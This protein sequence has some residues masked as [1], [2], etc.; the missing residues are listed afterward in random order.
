MNRKPD[1]IF[2]TKGKSEGKT[3]LNAFDNALLDAKIGN[4]NLSRVSSIVPKGV[5]IK[6]ELF[7][8]PGSVVPCVYSSIVSSEK[9]E[10]LSACVGAGLSKDSFGLIFE[11][12]HKGT[13]KIAEEIV[14][15]MIDEGFENRS[16]SLDKVVIISVEHK[17]QRIGSAIAAAV[18]WWGK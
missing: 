9:G 13:A 17:V 16:I 18:L 1:I 11:Y 3:A 6:K 7:I 5:R 10:I 4:L 12:A 8:A 2:F 15:K 14:R